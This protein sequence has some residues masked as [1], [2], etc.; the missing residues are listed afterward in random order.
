M[1]VGIKMFLEVG[2]CLRK[3]KHKH[4]ASLLQ[5]HTC[6]VAQKITQVRVYV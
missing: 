2:F 1:L 3:Q 5:L 6:N 4:M